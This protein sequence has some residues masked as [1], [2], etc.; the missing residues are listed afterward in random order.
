MN[1]QPSRGF[2]L[3]PSLRDALLGDEEWQSVLRLFSRN[4]KRLRDCANPPGTGHAPFPVT[5]TGQND[6]P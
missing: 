6:D 2:V 4:G 3:S 1:L 5:L